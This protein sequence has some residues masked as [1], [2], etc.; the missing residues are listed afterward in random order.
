MNLPTCHTVIELPSAMTMKFDPIITNP[1][2]SISGGSNEVF[3]ESVC[4]CGNQ[5]TANLTELEMFQGIDPPW[6]PVE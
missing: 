2:G 3:L 6:S 1:D 5:W 4:S